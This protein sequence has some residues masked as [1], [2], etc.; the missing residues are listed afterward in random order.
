VVAQE[1]RHDPFL[2]LAAAALAT[3]RIQLGTA[4][5][6]A[7]PRSPTV[8]AMQAWDIHSASSGRFYLGLG[9]QVKAH[10]ERRFGIAWSAPEPRMRDYIG[11]TRALWRCWE[12]KERLN[13]RSEH[14]TLTLMTPN[15][16]PEP[17][18][19]ALPPVAIGA[20][21]PAMLRL[22]GERCDGVRLHPFSTR[23]HLAE[24]SIPNIEEGLRRSARRREDIEIVSGGLIATGRDR[25][26]MLKMREHVRFRIA[27]YSSTRA[28]WD[29]LRLHGLSDL[30]EKLLDYSRAGRWSEMATL[31]PDEIV[32][33][34]AICGTG[35]TLAE[36]IEERHGELTDTIELPIAPAD[37]RD[38]DPLARL[39]ETI[40]RI[41]SPFKGYTD[42]WSWTQP[43]SPDAEGQ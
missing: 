3:E 32:D 11:A 5:A 25:E 1:N 21:G 26:S 9:S 16:A 17:T 2:A 24:I 37:A 27:F 7:F 38:R 8:T 22:A 15:F 12:K 40:Q 23:K 34:F 13:F 10:N 4:V 35:D 36:Q 29:A 30:G 28:Y 39:V 14:Y 18:G 33:L 43:P 19:L 6:I 20:V 41:P 31:I 42:G